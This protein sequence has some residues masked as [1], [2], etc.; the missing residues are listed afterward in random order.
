MILPDDLR[1]W[2]D[3]WVRFSIS[4]VLRKESVIPME[5]RDPL[6]SI[7]NH[8]LQLGFRERGFNYYLPGSN[9]EVK[10]GVSLNGFA[11]E[12]PDGM[13]ANLCR[14][15]LPESSNF[16]NMTDSERLRLELYLADCQEV[17]T[18]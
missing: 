6:K 3:R 7:H 17:D 11:L 4:P 10:C 1:E 5:A 9:P 15:G 8:L 18:L 14:Y 13:T 12:G 2:L 16:K